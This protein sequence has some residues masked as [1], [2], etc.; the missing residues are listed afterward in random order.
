M[1]TY[2]SFTLTINI[3]ILDLNK[4]SVVEGYPTGGANS[5]PSGNGGNS[6]P[7]AGNGG[8]NG[9]PSGPSAGGNR[10]PSGNGGNNGY[11]S[12]PTGGGAGF[13]SGPAA[14]GA[15][16]RPSNQYVPQANNQQPRPSGNGGFS[17]QSGYNY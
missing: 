16:G 5:Y 1:G 6:Y 2:L 3:Y 12:G 17:P 10:G 4:F 7:G 11:P 14:G 15:G 9:Y 8:N 13:P